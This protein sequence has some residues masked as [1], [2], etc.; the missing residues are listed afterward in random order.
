M[1]G[2]KSIVLDWQTWLRGMSSSP[3][4]AD[5]GFSSETDAVNLIAQPGVVYAPAS[6]VDSDTDTRLSGNGEIIATSPDMTAFGGNERLLVAADGSQDGTFFRYNGTKISAA[7]YATDT[8]RNYQKG[9]TD[10]ITFAGEA[11][12]TSKETIVRWQ[13]DNTITQDFFTFDTSYGNTIPHP[14]IIF[15]NNAFYGSRDSSGRAILLRQTA[16]AGTPAT[17]LTLTADQIII[18]LGIDPGS[19]K[20]L[21]ST[22]NS[23]NIS[24]TIPAINKVLWYDGFSNKVS[25]S[26]IVEDM[27][28]A[29]HSHGG[30]NF[31]GYGR[32]LGYLNGAGIT[33]LRKLLN[34]TNDDTKLPHK[35]SFASLG[36]TMYVIDGSQV[37]AYGP[38]GSGNP[39][40]YYA[41]K[42]RVSSNIY[43]CIF[44]A[45]G[46]S[47]SANSKLGLS[48]ATEKFYTFDVV[49][50]A[51][52][53][54]LNLFTNWIIFPRPVQIR[55][56]SVQFKAAI[57]SSA[58]YA[59]TYYD[60]SQVAIKGTLTYFDGT[61]T[62][63]TE[64][65]NIVGFTDKLTALKIELSFGT[66][67]R[68]LR[69]IT[70][71]Y[72]PVE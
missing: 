36:Q 58:N 24:Q 37:L 69:L 65:N 67:N 25:K 59:F 57:T 42:N 43:A 15:E 52:I 68:G 1:I 23:L 72:D 51:T 22:T 19:G 40:W 48:F 47:G 31:V 63:V 26:I 10:I 71:Y 12:V 28:T 39:I 27:I 41:H 30:T 21:I 14:A 53:D 16:A 60:Q 9:F 33:F 64:L 62:S 18:A 32:N 50:V 66:D 29:I 11:Y 6:A 38:V 49:S 2:S 46:T 34:V 70:I 3:E 44:N 4:I 20:M 55:S 13:A 17:I 35:H 45:G 61:Q 7:A 54:E 5:G 8:T 56:L